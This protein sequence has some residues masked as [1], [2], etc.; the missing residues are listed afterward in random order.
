MDSVSIGNPLRIARCEL[1]EQ[2]VMWKRM[3]WYHYRKQGRV[4]NFVCV[5]ARQ[6]CCL[7]GEILLHSD[8]YRLWHLHSEWTVVIHN[9]QLSRQF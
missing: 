9:G 4:G 1:M 6:S 2:K 8:H 3:P 7:S 5:L